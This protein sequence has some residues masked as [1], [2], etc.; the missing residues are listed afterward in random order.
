MGHFQI[1]SLTNFRLAPASN[2]RF[3]VPVI[4][5]VIA[6]FLLFCL[7]LLVPAS[8]SPFRV[9]F[10]ED[11]VLLPGWG[12]ARSTDSEKP[13]CCEDCDG[14]KDGSCC[15]D[16]KKFP[17]APE[18]SSPIFRVPVRF[19]LPAAEAGLPPRP[20]IALETPFVP[21]APIRGRDSPG[22][23]RALLEIWNI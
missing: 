15:L 2:S 23:R 3:Y 20:V 13:K 8:A 12:V 14:E 11:A 5:R 7:V 17:D 9:C 18:P 1:G 16:V 10:I 22:E 6:T 21:S 19:C 4:R